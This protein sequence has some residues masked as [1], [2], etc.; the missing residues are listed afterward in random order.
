ME[1][2]SSLQWSQHSATGH[3]AD[4]DESNSHL[5]TLFP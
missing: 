1:P 2:E 4:P 5:P 3:Y